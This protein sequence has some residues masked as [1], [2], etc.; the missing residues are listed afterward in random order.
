MGIQTLY[1]NNNYLII[2]AVCVETSGNE[3][4]SWIIEAILS[5]IEAVSLTAALDIH[6]D[7]SLTLFKL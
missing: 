5:C 4:T 2:Q 3:D 7:G 1:V 6:L